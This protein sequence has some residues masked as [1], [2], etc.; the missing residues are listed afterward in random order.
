MEGLLIKSLMTRAEYLKKHIK[1]QETQ[2]DVSMDR[3]PLTDS[4]RSLSSVAPMGT[5]RNATQSL[6]VH[7][8][9]LHLTRFQPRPNQTCMTPHPNQLYTL[10]GWESAVVS[11]M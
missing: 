5:S 8:S 11:Q 3:E 6:P 10:S 9:N 2:R 1:M 7:E 4:V